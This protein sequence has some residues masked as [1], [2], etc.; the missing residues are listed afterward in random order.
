VAEQPH[1]KDERERSP[2]A[3]HRLFERCA[4]RTAV[5]V[6]PRQ[7][8]RQDLAADGREQLANLRTWTIPSPATARQRLAGLEDQRLDLLASD[9]QHL[10]DLAVRVITE[11]KE[12]Q[13]SALILRQPPDVL[14]DLAEQLAPLDLVRRSLL[15][16]SIDDRLIQTHRVAAR[17]KL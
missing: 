4:P 15:T 11:L 10:G 14:E 6:R 5:D 8:P 2:L 7:A 13:R 17:A 3:T 16:R 12:N 1:G 9:P